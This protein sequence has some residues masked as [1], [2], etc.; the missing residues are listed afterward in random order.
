MQLELVKNNNA[1]GAVKPV[2]KNFDE[3]VMKRVRGFHKSMWGYYKPTRLVELKE[4]AEWFGV[5]G[6]FVKDE[7]S[8]FGL[9]AFK[10]LGGSY[11]IAAYLAERLGKNV[12]DVDFDYLTSE[13]V[14]EKL[15]EITFATTTDGNH[16]RGIAWAARVF[17]FK[18]V[19]YMPKGTVKERAVIIANEGAAVKITDL[20]YDDTV[21]MLARDAAANGWIV[22]QD[23]SWEGYTQV[24]LAIMQGYTTLV[25]EALE[26]LPEPATHV[27]A[28]AGV[29]S[30]AAAVQAVFVNKGQKPVF[31]ILEAA[32][33]NCF[34]RSFQNNKMESVGGDL[35][36][37]MAGLACGEIS[38]L[39]WDIL[40]NYSDYVVSC[41]DEVTALGMRILGNPLG[42]DQ[43]VIAGESGAVGAG[44]IGMLDKYHNLK[45]ELG[46]NKDSIILLFNTEGDTYA[47]G[48]RDIVWGGQLPFDY[49]RREE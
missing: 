3:Q 24:P 1:K 33:A 14:R 47:D 9:K 17:G 46:L 40:Y 11:A 38:P 30:F 41:R 45:T 22:M 12:E 23:T 4:L 18:S 19:V 34:Y 8:R 20:N 15:G 31:T 27:F 29:G 49:R 37:I 7:S 2:L 13:A 32:K 42:N 35:S 44:V 43:K 39:A 28:Q 6:I 26:E 16:G 5:K 36:T 48:Y 25:D 21:R 10:G